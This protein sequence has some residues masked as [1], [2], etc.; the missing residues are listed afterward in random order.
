M[1]GL[2]D[3]LEL[4]RLLSWFLYPSS[5][6]CPRLSSQIVVYRN[7]CPQP[8]V[9]SDWKGPK[10]TREQ[11]DFLPFSPKGQILQKVN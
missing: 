1:A 10:L 2:P 5:M 8:N 4:S 9:A 7:I 6:L 11:R 3:P